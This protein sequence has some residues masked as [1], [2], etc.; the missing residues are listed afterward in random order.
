MRLLIIGPQGA[1]KGTQAALLAEHL[2]VPHVSTGDLFRA[3]VGHGTEL[4][5]Q[6]QKFMDAGNLV[7]DTITSAMVAD[8]LAEPDA[9]GFLLDGFP[10]NL[11]QAEWFDSLCE[12]RG[13]VLDAVLLLTAPDEVLLE[14]MMARGRADDTEAAI[15]RRLSIYHTETTPLL[16]HYGPKVVRVDGVGAIED[17]QNRILV[18]LGREDLL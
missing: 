18:A 3:N 10:R 2:H 14:R 1:G 17:V 5:L 16:D 7:P 11:S 15:S 9:T 12:E 8:R 13:L 6:A 4:G